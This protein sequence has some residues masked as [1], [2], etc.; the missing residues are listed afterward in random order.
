MYEFLYAIG[1]YL[2]LLN[3]MVLFISALVFPQRSA[4]VSILLL[5]VALQLL[6]MWYQPYLMDNLAKKLSKENIRTLWYMG[7]AVT[8]FLFV[9]LAVSYCNIKNMVRDK[10]SNFIL[11]EVAVLGV[12]QMVR[13][14]DRVLIGSDVLGGFYKVAIPTL[15][16]SLTFMAISYVS[17]FCGAGFLSLISIKTKGVNK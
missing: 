1:E 2:L 8:D 17:Y 4:F 7:F 3:L 11:I 9:W 15:N 10:V 16:F 12:I 13:Y 14:A 5:A 6:H